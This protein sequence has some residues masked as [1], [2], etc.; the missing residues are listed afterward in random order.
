MRLFQEL[1][2]YVDN[3]NGD[4]LSPEVIKKTA[5]I[6]KLA[7]RVKTKMRGND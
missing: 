4:V 2:A 5:E 7:H 6:E 3:A 1:K